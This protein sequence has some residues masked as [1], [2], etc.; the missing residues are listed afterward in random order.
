MYWPIWVRCIVPITTKLV[1]IWHTY[2]NE[3][4]TASERRRY[5][6]DHNGRTRNNG[7]KKKIVKNFSILVA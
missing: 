4:S 3:L 6:Y 7:A 1:L 5:D 2:M